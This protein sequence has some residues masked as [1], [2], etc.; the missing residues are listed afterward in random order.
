MGHGPGRVQSS[1]LEVAILGI[2]VNFPAFWRRAASG[3]SSGGAFGTQQVFSFHTLL[4]VLALAAL[5]W[6]GALLLVSAIAHSGRWDL[7]SENLLETTLSSCQIEHVSRGG[8]ATEHMIC[9]TRLATHDFPQVLKDAVIASEDERFFSHGALEMRSTARAAWQ[10]FLGNRQGGSTLTQQLARTLFLKKED[11]LQRKLLEAVLAVRISALLSRPEILRRYM[12]VVPH[13]RNMYGFGD[14]ARYYFGARVQDL[15]LA[16]AALLVGMLPE[17]NNRDPKKNPSAA[18]NGALGVIDLMLAQNKITGDVADEARDELKRRVVGGRLRRGNEPYARLEYRPYRDLSLREARASGIAL[19]ADYR[20]VVFIDAEFQHRV[21]GQICGI[22]G[23]HQSAGFFMRPSGEVLAVSGS[24]N[25]SG[26]WNRASDIVRSIGSTGKLF[27][28]IGVREASM[29]MRERVSTRPLRRPDWPS[30]VNSRCLKNRAV[31]LDFALAQSCNRPWTEIAMRL[32]QRLN[33][34]VKRFAIAPPGAPA[35]VPIG[36]IYTS[37]MK[38]TQ[39][40]GALANDGI[41]PQVRFLVA[42]IGG[43]GN[44][45]G[46]PPIKEAQRVM[47]PR[48]AA[49]VL[50]D[51]RAP[52]RQGTA[53]SANSVHALVYGKTG[54]SSRNEDALFVGLTRD[55]VG[56]FWLGYDRPTPMP[57]VHGGGGPAKAFSAMTDFHYLKLA[58]AQLIAKREPKDEWSELRRITPAEPL[59]SALVF[60]AMLTMCLLLTIKPRHV[61]VHSAAPLPADD[62]P[63]AMSESGPPLPASK[64]S[65]VDGPWGGAIEAGT[66]SHS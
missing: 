41:L 12:N 59:R 40:Y 19:A 62:Q 14:P 46:V 56:S 61:G 30:E 54:T 18:L 50:Q 21:A 58:R 10:Y 51:L 2:T 15:T 16:E 63:H 37:P 39:A 47:S 44:V 11:S 4:G 55:F 25:Y 52:V 65:V 8:I 24:C 13:A 35:L 57:G 3:L 64:D 27:P 1:A 23:K 60:G 43:K 29:S 26:A 34:I 7:P 42:V 31:S 53:R 28:L 9:P 22:A 5:A 48:T 36:G 38:L 6:S 32:G 49:A 17:P 33:D 45:L 20:L 66:I